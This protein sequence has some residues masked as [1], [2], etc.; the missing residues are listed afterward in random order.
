MRTVNQTIG[1]AVRHKNDK[2]DI[3]LIDSRFY[4]KRNKI[5]SW[6]RQRIEVIDHMEGL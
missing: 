4:P 1:R 5:A 2:A 3:Y 6:L